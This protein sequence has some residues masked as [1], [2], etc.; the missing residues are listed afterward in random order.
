[1]ATSSFTVDNLI[2]GIV[3]AFHE[4]HFVSKRK[5]SR[6]LNRVRLTYLIL[7]D[8]G[9][10][11]TWT[12]LI[13][14]GT[15]PLQ[16][17]LA[18]KFLGT[19]FMHSKMG[20]MMFISAYLCPSLVTQ[21]NWGRQFSATIWWHHEAVTLQNWLLIADKL[22]TTLNFSEIGWKYMSCL[23]PSLTAVTITRLYILFLSKKG[24]L[25]HLV[26]NTE[27][28]MESEEAVEWRWWL[29]K[30]QRARCLDGNWV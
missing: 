29:F 12:V 23:N 27:L 14:S 9:F 13:T 2:Y 11:E 10:T 25:S 16:R 18:I 24:F 30:E 6:N 15:L 28:L 3:V 17:T 22:T 7:N 1:M 21:V 5:C 19:Y 26:E 8:L 4:G 20:L